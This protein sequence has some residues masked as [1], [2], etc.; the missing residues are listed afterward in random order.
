MALMAAVDVRVRR[1][2]HATRQRVHLARLREHLGPLHARHPLVAD[3]DGQRV[4][5][6]L[7]LTDGGER[8]FTRRRADDR[9]G[10]AIARA[11]IAAHRREHLRVVVDDEDDGFVHD[12][13][14]GAPASAMRQRHA[15]LASVRAPTRSRS[16][17]RCGAT[18]RRTMS[19]PRPVPLPTGLVV[20]KGS[21]MRS[22][23][24]AGMPRRRCRPPA[25]RR[26]AARRPAVTSTR[27]DSGT[28]SSALSIR[29]AQIWLSSPTKPAGARQVR[30]HGDRDG[31][32][33]RPGLRL[34]DR[35]GVVQAP[36]R[37]PRA[38]PPWPDPCG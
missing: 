24:S 34:E 19:R 18:S 30:I 29:F 33:F 36:T 26:V 17:R 2:Q 28:A 37:R 35:D 5:S 25:R 1:Q 32:R 11:E 7:Q 20:K 13:A 31:G 8:L 27:P 15:E 9:I 10:L 21:K 16:R 14:A 22:R 4:A 12:V 23:I 3:Q 38:R 6:R